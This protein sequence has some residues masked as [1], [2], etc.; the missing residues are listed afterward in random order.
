MLYAVRSHSDVLLLVAEVQRRGHDRPAGSLAVGDLLKCSDLVASCWRFS[1]FQMTKEPLA[2]I[3]RKQRRAQRSRLVHSSSMASLVLE[4]LHR[5]HRDGG[6][7]ISLE[8]FPA[9]TAAGVNNLLGRIQRMGIRLQPTFVTLTWRS[10]F[11]DESLWLQIGRTVQQQFGI[12]VM[13]HLTCHLPVADL[14]RIL[15]RVR[16]AGIRNILALRGDPPIGEFYWKP[17]VGGFAHAVELVRLIRHEH[18]D[19]FCVAVA[20]YPEVHTECWNSAVLPPSQECMMRDLTHLKEKVD[21]GAD[22]IVTQ[23]FYSVPHFIHYRDKCRNVGIEVPV[24]AG[25]LPIQNYNSFTKFTSWC[26]T[27]VPQEMR[28]KLEVIKNDDEAV[29]IF[30]IGVAVK[31]INELL[32]CGCRCL[33]FYTMNLAGATTK[34]LEGI[35]LVPKQ[36]QQTLPWRLR[37]QATTNIS[38]RAA[39]HNADSQDPVDMNSNNAVGMSSNG[40]ASAAYKHMPPSD[41]LDRP[42]SSHVNV[43]PAID[44]SHPSRSTRVRNLDVR[45]N[46]GV[47]PC[48]WL[49]RI[50][51]AG[52]NRDQGGGHET[53]GNDNKEGTRPIFWSHREESYLFRTQDWDEFPNGRWGDNRSPAYG[54]LTD[55]YLAFKR[56]KVN[57][58]ELWGTPNCMQDVC[59]VFVRYVEGAI[60]QLPWCE[61]QL[62]DESAPLITDLKWINAAGFLT[63]NSQPRVNAA[64]SSDPTVGWGGPNGHVFQKAYIEFFC[65]P[66]LL[67]SLLCVLNSG[68]AM[69]P[70]NNSPDFGQECDRWRNLTYHAINA[71]GAAVVGPPQHLPLKVNAV[72]WG[73]FPGREIIQPTVV[74]PESFRTWKDE[75]FGLWLSQW[76]TMYD[77]ESAAD[78]QAR[79][80]IDE[81]HDSWWLMNI[82]DN[83]YVTSDLAALGSLLKEVIISSMT[84]HELRARV[85]LLEEKNAVLRSELWNLKRGYGKT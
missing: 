40:N 83:D 26:R 84:Q 8:F 65:S 33:H 50:D 2:V 16:A 60:K 85:R 5:V 32:A 43:S 37:R 58:R 77:E 4:K 18:G 72:T 10:A 27:L 21:A 35:G 28:S 1:R 55:Y 46:R 76:A 51:T 23:F 7:A 48:G 19:W 73:V 38:L 68:R 41:A 53:L 29:K 52:K 44:G 59:D 39:S 62:A 47:Y 36:Y 64:P 11:K 79:H 6:T 34:V 56:P 57:R 25:H 66:Q 24:V 67:E 31:I 9:K 13:L 82:A 78:V 80:L 45:D 61:Q 70:K 30:G 20:G 22:F 54:E 42:P 12:D 3:A 71:K 17:R 63:I 14:R 81:V 69:A 74:D 49:S 15:L 75:A